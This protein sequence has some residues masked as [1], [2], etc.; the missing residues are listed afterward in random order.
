MNLIGK[1]LIAPP[2]VKGNIWQKSV[3][4]I[5]E[6]HARASVGL[7]VNK[8]SQVS[9]KEFSKQ[10]NVL[11][12]IPG[13]M[14]IGGPVNTKAMTMLHTSEWSCDNTM[15]IN[16]EFSLSSSVDIFNQLAMG[17]IPKKWRLFVGLCGWN[18]SQLENE[19][20]GTHGYEHNNSWLLCAAD[21]SLVFGYEQQQQWAESVE[22]SGQEFVQNILA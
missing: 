4:Y 14:Y 8:R 3:V 2:T 17:N 19:I 11:L 7:V 12:D 15:Q 1:L 20:R 22:R 10:A 13:Y 16:E 21:P 9:I 18:S 6:H 5:T